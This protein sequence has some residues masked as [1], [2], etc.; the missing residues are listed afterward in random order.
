ML[1][2]II[3]LY[4]YAIKTLYH[5]ISTSFTKLSRYGERMDTQAAITLNQLI[6]LDIKLGTAKEY[7]IRAVFTT[8]ILSVW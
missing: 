6:M 3:K 7:N 8:S 2:K 1:T 5:L 4:N